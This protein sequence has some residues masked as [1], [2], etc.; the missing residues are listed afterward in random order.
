MTAVSDGLALYRTMLT[1]RLFE[2]AA[3]AWNLEGSIRGNVH[4]YIGQEGIATGVCSVLRDDDFVASYHRG[5][6]HT[7]AKGADPA[8]MMAELFGR[9]S[10]TC[11]GKAG[12]L[13]IADLSVG[14]LGANGVI[15]DGVTMSVGAVHATRLLGSD[16]VAVAFFGDGGLN[17]GPVLESLNWAKAFDLPVLFVCEDNVYAYTQRTSAVTGG[18]GATARATGFGVE[19]RT[20]DGNDVIAVREAAEAMVTR[21]RQ[22]GGPML[23]HAMTYRTTGHIAVDQA[24]YRIRG[25]ASRYASLDPILRCEAW[26]ANHDVSRSELERTRAE[27][28]GKIDHAVEQAQRAPYP[29]PDAAF[30]DLQDLGAPTWQQ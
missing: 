26:L 6:G 23:I 28:K 14:M 18:P 12:S 22:G 27:V 10:G 21:M 7:I 19:A 11:G 8:A 29:S 16:A 24:A 2:E 5:H 25:E 20:L 30:T 13:H 15:G 9:S 4:P 1:I 17:R 3:V